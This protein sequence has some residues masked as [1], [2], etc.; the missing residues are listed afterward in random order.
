MDIV[1]LQPGTDLAKIV[2]LVSKK[3]K[4]ILAKP[5]T[6]VRISNSYWDGGSRSDYFLVH[7][8][9]K[10]VTP[11]AGVSPMQFGGPKEDPIQKIEPG[12]AVV[13]AGT[14]CGKPSTPTVYLHPEG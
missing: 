12:Y 10:T 5:T 11:I 7:I 1:T 14:F 2:K 3:R 6:E 8:A 13:E 9:S 4:A